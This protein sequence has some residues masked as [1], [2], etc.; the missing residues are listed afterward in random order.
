MTKETTAVEFIRRIFSDYKWY[1]KFYIKKESKYGKRVDLY[2]DL[3]DT[4]LIIEID[5]NQHKYYKNEKKRMKYITKA[6]GKPTIFIRF[7]PDE[8]W[9]CNGE[10]HKSCWEK[11]NG[12]YILSEEEHEY[13]LSNLITV[14]VNLY[15]DEIECYNIE[16]SEKLFYVVHKL[17]YDKYNP[18]NFDSDPFEEDNYEICYPNSE[19]D[20][21]E[22]DD[23]D[24]DDIESEHDTDDDWR[25]NCEDKSE[26][27]PEY[28]DDSDESEPEYEDSESDDSDDDCTPPPSKRPKID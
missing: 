8:Y 27:E 26:S 15:N 24:D 9:D 18:G 4:I 13:R 19:T 28:E 7:N 25:P 21:D 16:D 1:I 17:Y 11:V 14:I 20:S 3:D 5:E 2:L 22:D 23:L 10:F 6:L 12:K